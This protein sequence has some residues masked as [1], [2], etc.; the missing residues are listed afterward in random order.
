MVTRQKTFF[1]EQT[2]ACEIDMPLGRTNDSTSRCRSVSYC[3]RVL[4]R[5]TYECPR[6]IISKSS[7][8]FNAVKF[9]NR[10]HVKELCSHPYRFYF[11]LVLVLFI[12]DFSFISARSHPALIIYLRIHFY[13]FIIFDSYSSF[14]F[15]EGSSR[16]RLT[17]HYKQKQKKR[18]ALN[19]GNEKRVQIGIENET[20]NENLQIVGKTVVVHQKE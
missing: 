16:V 12:S 5:V 1:F 7:R 9:F 6:F 17:T 14:F 4:I 13:S 2:T 10:E 18:H 15:Y 3:K 11:V 8:L 20:Y 19:E